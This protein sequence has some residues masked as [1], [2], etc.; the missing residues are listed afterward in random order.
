MKTVISVTN[1]M[2][3]EN[4]FKIQMVY[5]NFLDNA[6]FTAHCKMDSIARLSN[7]ELYPKKYRDKF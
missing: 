2:L 6:D 5:K 3:Q 4:M 7:E 1:H